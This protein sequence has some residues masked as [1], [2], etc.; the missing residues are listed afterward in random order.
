MLLFSYFVQKKARWV[1]GG[2]LF[3][4]RRRVTLPEDQEVRHQP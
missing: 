2:Y 3:A 1:A 4:F